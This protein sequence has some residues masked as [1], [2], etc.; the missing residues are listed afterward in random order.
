MAFLKTM[1]AFSPYNV[2][3]DPNAAGPMD[4][5]YETALARYKNVPCDKLHDYIAEGLVAWCG[6]FKF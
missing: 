3:H 4:A 5:Y 6:R 1:L 2:D